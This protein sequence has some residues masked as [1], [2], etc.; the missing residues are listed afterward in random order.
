MQ[1]WLRSRAIRS[2]MGCMDTTPQYLQPR[3]RCSRALSCELAISQTAPQVLPRQRPWRFSVCL[4]PSQT[5]HRLT[6]RPLSAGRQ[7]TQ[8]ADSSAQHSVRQALHGLSGLQGSALPSKLG[9]RLRG[10]QPTPCR[11]MHVR[12]VAAS[13]CIGF[14]ESRDHTKVPLLNQVSNTGVSMGQAAS[15]QVHAC[16]ICCCAS[17]QRTWLNVR[18]QWPHHTAAA[19]VKAATWGSPWMLL[20]CQHALDAAARASPVTSPSCNCRSSAS[21]GKSLHGLGSKPAA[22]KLSAALE[23]TEESLEDDAEQQQAPADLHGMF[24][25]QLLTQSQQSRDHSWC[26]HLCR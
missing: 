8:A 23:G 1:P 6:A 22:P 2:Q 9:D 24:I 20:L 16:Q 12:S 11:C 17:T 3:W 7:H 25:P 26:M 19:E 21:K 14:C 4:A 13:A 18:A 5:G 15:L 10:W